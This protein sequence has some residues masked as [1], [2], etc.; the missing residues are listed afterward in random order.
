MNTTIISRAA[1]T[2]I[3]V[4]SI[5]FINWLFVVIPPVPVPAFNTVFPPVML[6][7]GFVFV[8]RDFCQRAIGHHVLFAM[9]AGGVVSYFMSAPAVAIA[10]VAAFSISESV[11]WLVYTFTRKPLSQRI[12]Y[13]SLIS[14][15]I[16]TVV[17]LKLVDLFDF[18]GSFLVILAKFGGAV[19]F[20]WFLRVRE[21]N[22]L[23]LVEV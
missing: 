10:S 16:D 13:S 20:W 22:H 7:V 18:A 21:A 11:D 15:P 3:Y 2:V 8:F 14:V 6:V 19:V 12:L 23:V 1:W 17:F 5:A 9:L 4:S